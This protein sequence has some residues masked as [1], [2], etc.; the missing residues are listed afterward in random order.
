MKQRKVS[1]FPSGSSDSSNVADGTGLRESSNVTDGTGLRE[2]AVM[3][4]MGQD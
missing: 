1:E 2:R 3:L 4:L